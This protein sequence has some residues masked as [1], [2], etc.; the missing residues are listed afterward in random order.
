VKVTLQ[1][2]FKHLGAI[3]ES[4]NVFGLTEM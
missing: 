3:E 4:V 1:V 2:C